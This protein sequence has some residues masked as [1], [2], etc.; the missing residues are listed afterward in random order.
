MTLG[1]DDPFKIFQTEEWYINNF[2]FED[3]F[4]IFL[5]IEEFPFTIF[6]FQ[7]AQIFDP[8]A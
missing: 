5:K 3:L 4:L 8:V 2:I 6:I 1:Y 7:A